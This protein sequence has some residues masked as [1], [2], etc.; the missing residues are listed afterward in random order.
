MTQLFPAETP[1]NDFSKTSK[2]LYGFPKTGKTTLFAAMTDADGRPPLF[3]QSEEGQGVLKLNRVRVTSWEGVLRLVVHLEAHAAQL[4]AEHSCLVLDVVADFD[5]WCA[6]FIC[7]RM[8]IATLA[9]ETHGKGYDARKTE[10]RAAMHRLMALLPVSYIAHTKE[11]DLTWENETR[12]IHAPNLGMNCLEFLN[13]KVDT[14]MWISPETSKKYPEILVKSS[15]TAIA[16][17]RF[18]QLVRNF[19]YN[20]RKPVETY[21]AIEKAFYDGMPAADAPSEAPIIPDETAPPQTAP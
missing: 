2:L 21:R 17:S 19:P 5:D 9:D 6:A 12:K 16:G 7:K 18:P 11:R 13:G 8:S 1:Q 20:W 15:M 3:L 14:V 4:K 10:F